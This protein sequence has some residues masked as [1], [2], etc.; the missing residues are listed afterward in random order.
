M[1]TITAGTRVKVFFIGL[2]PILVVAVFLL[3]AKLAG[4]PFWE[5]LTEHIETNPEGYEVVTTTVGQE[6]STRA[7]TKQDMVVQN[8]VPRLYAWLGVIAA[9]VVTALGTLFVVAAC[10]PA[11]NKLLI[12]TAK[13]VSEPPT[14]V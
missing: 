14:Q 1:S 9:L 12:W 2:F 10:L 7:A 5:A 8:A 3:V 4:F 13:K 6:A 11:N